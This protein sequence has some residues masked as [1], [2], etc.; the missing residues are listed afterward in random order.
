MFT[1]DFGVVVDTFLDDLSVEAQANSQSELTS[2]RETASDDCCAGPCIHQQPG[3]PGKPGQ[4]KPQ[5]KPK[6]ARARAS[7]RREIERKIIVKSR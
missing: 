4:P 1:K 5:P 2:C 6:I 7:I 3:K